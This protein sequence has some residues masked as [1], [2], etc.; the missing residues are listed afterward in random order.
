M[1]DT[2]EIAIFCAL[3]VLFAGGLV[4]IAH[5]ARADLLRIAAYALI[6]VSV[7]YVGFSLGSDNPKFWLGFEMTGVAVFGSLAMMGL[8][9]K[10]WAVVLGL[11]LHPAWALAFHYYGT[12]APFTPA[13][14][15]VGDAAFD[16]AL[17]LAAGFVLLRRRAAPVEASSIKNKERVR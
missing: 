6:A 7:I 3:G 9:G 10:R 8:I 2:S 17:G 14:F 5:W 4:F 16:I 15:A 11:L 1:L 12:G 13:P